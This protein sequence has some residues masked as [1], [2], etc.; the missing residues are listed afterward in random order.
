RGWQSQ[1]PGAEIRIAMPNAFGFSGFGGAPI[2]VQVMG[3]DPATLD[4]LSTQIEAA[5]RT[6]P[7]AADVKNGNDNR[8]S[9]LRATVDWTRA[10]DLGVTPLS[11]GVALRTA[12]D[13]FTANGLQFRQAGKTAVP[14]RVLRDGAERMAPED[15]SRLPVGGSRGNVDLG[16]FTT[17]H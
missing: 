1:I 3:E 8:Q 4:E 6:A 13:W 12:L 7:G 17:L 2:Q 14:I 16:Q 15:V 9:Q 10:A 11:A 5:V